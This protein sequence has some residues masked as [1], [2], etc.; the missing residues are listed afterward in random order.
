MPS[1]RV[2]YP[3]SLY[4]NKQPPSIFL[5]GNTDNPDNSD[6]TGTDL[7]KA[8]IERTNPFEVGTCAL[9]GQE[10][11]FKGLK[12]SA[13]EPV[14]MNC[15][16]DYQEALRRN[17]PQESSTLNDEKGAPHWGK[18]ANHL[19]GKYTFATREDDKKVLY[20]DSSQGI[21]KNASALIEGTVKALFADEKD[22][23]SRYFIE[24][25]KANIQ[26]ST[27][28]SP[29]LFNSQDGIVV[30]NGVFGS[31]LHPFDPN[32]YDTIRVPVEYDKA[33]A[34]I[35]FRNAL[36]QWLP[37]EVDRAVLQEY[38]GYCL[39]KDMPHHKALMLTGKGAN[40]KSTFLGVVKSLLGSENIASVSLQD[41]NERAFTHANLIGKLALVYADLSDKPLRETGSFK[42]LTG[43]DMIGA[44]MKYVQDRVN[45][46]NYAK[47]I[48]SANKLPL[49]Y[50]DSDAF[51]RRMIVV[52]FPNRFSGEDADHYL[53][54]KLT[55]PESLSGVLNWALEGR[56]RLM[57][58][59]WFSDNKT[60]EER[61]SEYKRNSD[62]VWG[63]V[64]DECVIGNPLDDIPKGALYEIYKRWCSEHD[65]RPLQDYSF[66]KNLKRVVPE[67]G[68]ERPTRAGKRVTIWTGIRPA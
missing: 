1:Y 67:I 52:D 68:E 26:W 22:R 4:L 46:V 2:F 3:P 21:Y 12:V 8:L 36:T 31:N 27:Y 50:D 37:D 49:S 38:V 24:E 42:I 19:M 61:R 43:G 30:A 5:M 58:Q 41:L 33:A 15:H 54:Q 18:V 55:T 10:P 23:P 13:F 16:L 60:I 53:L 40:G 59:G 14:G 34:A 64:Q 62:P 63:F 35:D 32:R 51:F 66:G 45:F 20:F 65:I 39:V 29:E 11:G 17:T 44:E 7:E 9:C 47:L 25:T 48:Y 6:L 57:S 56:E 28:V